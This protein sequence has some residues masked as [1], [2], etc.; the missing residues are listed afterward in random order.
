MATKR[1]AL[2]VADAN[3]RVGAAVQRKRSKTA[4]KAKQPGKVQSNS[5]PAEATSTQ[6][7]TKPTAQPG[8]DPEITL[9][10]RWSKISN[11]ANIDMNYKDATRDPTEAYTYICMCRA[12]GFATKKG[13]YDEDSDSDPDPD[14]DPTA[15]KDSQLALAPCDYGTTCICKHPAATH[16]SH[17][18]ILSYAG[19]YRFGCTRCH[20]ESRN[21][22]NFSMCT[23]AHHQALGVLETVQNLL[24][25]F[26]AA[27]HAGNRGEQWAVV[28][29]TAMFLLSNWGAAIIFVDD[30]RKL[31]AT[32]TQVATMALATFAALV[33]AGLLRQNAEEV[34]NVGIVMSMYLKLLYLLKM[35]YLGEEM[36]ALVTGKAA[37]AEKEGVGKR[38]WDLQLA[39]FGS[40]V[41]TYATKY[42]VSLC[43][44]E[45]MELYTRALDAYIT[46]PKEGGDM[47]GWADTFAVY[48][49]S[50]LLPVH[51]VGATCT[52]RIGGDAFDVT[53][54]S[55]EK[56][57]EHSCD[58]KGA[59]TELEIK[60]IQGGHVL[61]ISHR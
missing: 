38:R 45:G 22:A 12:P 8:Y 54:W 2:A 23:F 18:W 34:Q 25:D 1:K 35:V 36:R 3:A 55:T 59:L 39:R 9:S 28:E 56:R 7:T 42:G 51:I 13:Y 31:E 16:P 37:M 33:E 6:D 26:D 47:W 21:P 60:A 5:P 14:T 52:G 27:R 53:S 41:L 44:V 32:V 17:Q 43:G 4:S 61:D 49:S 11:S 30:A 29:A 19:Y 50:C 20:A 40:Y 46:L 58:G 15:T 24:L 10:A 48:R 57:A